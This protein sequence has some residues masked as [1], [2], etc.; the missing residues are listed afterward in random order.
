[1]ALFRRKITQKIKIKKIKTHRRKKF[2]K[3]LYSIGYCKNSKIQVWAII[4]KLYLL[5]FKENIGKA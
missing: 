3:N 4:T 5:L 2:L 1:M